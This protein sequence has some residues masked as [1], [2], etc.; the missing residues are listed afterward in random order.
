MALWHQP[1][2]A[3]QRPNSDSLGREEP[4]QAFEQESAVHRAGLHAGAWQ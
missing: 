2:Q 1:V 3:S 4:L